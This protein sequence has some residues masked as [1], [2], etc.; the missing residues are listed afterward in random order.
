MAA[1]VAVV[2]VSEAELVVSRN[3]PGTGPSAGAVVWS[4][5]LKIKKFDVDEY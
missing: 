5:E 4:V 1:A 2:A 3:R